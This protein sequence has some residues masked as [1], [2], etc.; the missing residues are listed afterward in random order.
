M[1]RFQINASGQDSDRT[2]IPAQDVLAFFVQTHFPRHVFGLKLHFSGFIAVAEL[3][4]I[5]PRAGFV[6]RLLTGQ[7]DLQ[8]A[9]HSL[10]VFASSTK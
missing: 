4:V 10:A 7:E 8:F 6:G 3:R 9:H 2:L 1:H 5:R